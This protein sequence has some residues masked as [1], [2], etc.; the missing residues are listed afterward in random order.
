[1]KRTPITDTISYIEP[2]GIHP[3]ISCAALVI[4]SS[5]KIV[6]D[7]N[8]SDA[9]TQSVLQELQP[10]RAY[11]THFHLDH[12]R[13]WQAVEKFSS[14]EFFI[15]NGEESMMSDLNAF[16]KS[17]PGDHGTPEL[18]DA[19]VEIGGFKAIEKYR[20]YDGTHRIKSGST[21][22]ECIVTPGHSPSHTSFYLPDN[23][24]LFAGD[25]GLGRF[26]PWYG[27]MNCRIPD[28]I[29]SVLKLK[30]YKTETLLTSHE[31]IIRSNIDSVWDECL[32]HF[33]TREKAIRSQLDAGKTIDDIVEKGIYFTNKG[34]VKEPMKT[35]VTIWDQVMLD[36]H[37]EILTNSSLETLYPDL[38][39]KMVK[40]MN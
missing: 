1:M 10:D 39:K 9:D 25:L 11:T 26:G 29:E 14:A 36:H 8:L 37:L 38:S 40:D 32:G 17:T 18:W 34:Q 21:T 5:P 3:S 31:G 35:I 28:Y 7:L 13:F 27:W 16:L 30:S 23:R 19:F 22:V 12:S 4:S 6:I 24:V 33:F 15:P 2:S 20:V